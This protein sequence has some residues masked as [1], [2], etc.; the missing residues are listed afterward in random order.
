MM[1]ERGIPRIFSLSPSGYV[2][3]VIARHSVTMILA[4]GIVFASDGILI[5]TGL[6]S[7][8]PREASC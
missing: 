4:A 1:S 2:A 6:A 8:Q 3:A 7:L 5:L